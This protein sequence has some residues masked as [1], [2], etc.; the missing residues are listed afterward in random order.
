MCVLGN[1]HLHKPT[2]FVVRRPSVLMMTQRTV[3]SE[4]GLDNLVR[5]FLAQRELSLPLD[6]RFPTDPE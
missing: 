3:F 5:G 1:S 6:V 2:L 4:T